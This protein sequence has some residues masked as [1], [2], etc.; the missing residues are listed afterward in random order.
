M[1]PP[2]W[3]LGD[4]STLGAFGLVET[5][6]LGLGDPPRLGAFGTA[7]APVPVAPPV[8]A[9][10]TVP[11]PPP[12]PPLG[13][14]SGAFA[15]SGEVPPPVPALGDAPGAFARGGEVPPPVPAVGD[16]LGAFARGEEVPPPH[17][18]AV[19][20]AAAALFAAPATVFPVSKCLPGSF[21]TFPPAELEPWAAP[22][23]EAL[24]G[25]LAWLLPAEFAPVPKVE[26]GLGWVVV[27]PATGAW[28]PAAGAGVPAAGVEVGAVL[29]AGVLLKCAVVLPPA[30]VDAPA[31]WPLVLPPFA[32]FAAG[33]VTGL[34]SK[35]SK[36][37]L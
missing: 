27:A 35:S 34:A 22:G 3:P 7:A 32:G 25:W 8:P 19:V 4:P 23:L 9:S 37:W 21:T 33:L 13:G 1:D 30:G 6:M 36:S 17:P 10:T 12:V 11:V 31:G 28:E 2:G 14:A 24:D 20:I 29:F 16:A 26:A 18:R 5:P 15:G